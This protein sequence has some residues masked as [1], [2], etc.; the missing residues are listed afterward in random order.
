[1]QWAL[2]K[3]TSNVTPYAKTLHSA[4]TKINYGSK[5]QNGRKFLPVGR[6]VQYYLLV[7]VTMTGLGVLGQTKRFLGGYENYLPALA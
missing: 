5:T 3:S 7:I 6:W 2:E 4:G 1:M